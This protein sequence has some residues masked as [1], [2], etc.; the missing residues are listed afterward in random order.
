MSQAQLENRPHG[1]LRMI[2]AK[3]REYDVL[4]PHEKAEVDLAQK[5]AR[6][7]MTERRVRV[8]ERTRTIC[9]MVVS[10][11]KGFE[12]ATATGLTVAAVKSIC[13]RLGLPFTTRESGRHR[14]VWLTDD[15]IEKLG[16]VS[17]D[18]AATVEQTME[19]VWTFL[20]A[21]DAL[22]LRRLLHVT[23]ATAP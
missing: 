7:R 9:S 16:E 5:A 4:P 6:A 14:F 22:I 3:R 20:C 15:S 18:Y 21:D 13:R 12:I 10:G 1:L 23:R 11:A 17:R 19:D 8:T 2:D